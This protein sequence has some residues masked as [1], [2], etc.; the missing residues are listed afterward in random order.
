MLL[1]AGITIGAGALTTINGAS[2]VVEAGTGYNFVEDTVFGGNSSAYNTYAT[3]T[4]SV[5]KLL[6]V[7]SVVAGIDITHLESKHIKMLVIIIFL[8]HYRIQLI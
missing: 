5:R 4:G 8:E 6:E 3:I 1:V 7:L 2:E